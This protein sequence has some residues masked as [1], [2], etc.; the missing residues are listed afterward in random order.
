MDEEK[1][2]KMG[3]EAY[4]MKPFVMRDIANTV[5]NVLDTKQKGHTEKASV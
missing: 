5:R 1:A 2:E 4:L 3:V